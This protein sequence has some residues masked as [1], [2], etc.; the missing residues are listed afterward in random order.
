[1]ILDPPRKGCDRAVLDAALS[2]GFERII[3]V[4]CNPSTLARDLKILTAAQ[5]LNEADNFAKTAHNI[6][7]T[8]KN[9][10]ETSQNLAENGSI[11]AKNGTYK[12]ASIQPYDMFPQTSHIETLV[13]LA[14]K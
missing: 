4:S 1:M 8:V 3:Y 11:E 14:R 2:A 12:I 13:C 6:A 5:I 7:E 9:P 10:A